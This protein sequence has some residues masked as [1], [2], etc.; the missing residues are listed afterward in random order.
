MCPEHLNVIPVPE[1]ITVEKLSKVLITTDTCNPARAMRR[2]LIEKHVGPDA[3]EQDCC[4]HLRNVH[5]GGV[6]ISVSRF[7]TTVLRNSLDEIDPTLRVK[8]LYT[9]FCRAYDKEFSRS[10][11]YYKLQGRCTL[12]LPL[13]EEK[14]SWSCTVWSCKGTGGKA[15]P[16]LRMLSSNLHESSIQ[17]RVLG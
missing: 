13:D 14:P 2:V 7:L 3:L 8:T 5:T 1:T 9:P 15:R 16:H 6:E 12:V 4:N 11:N 10:A 17:S